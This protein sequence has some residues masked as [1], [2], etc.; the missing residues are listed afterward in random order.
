[1]ILKK[2]ERFKISNAKVSN[3]TVFYGYYCTISIILSMHI[4]DQYRYTQEEQE[5]IVDLT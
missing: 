2:F 1:M 3:V 5:S 4:I